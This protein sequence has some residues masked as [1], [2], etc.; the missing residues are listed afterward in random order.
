VGESG[1]GTA[2]SDESTGGESSEGGAVA[3]TGTVPEQDGVELFA[4]LCA[5]C[6]GAEGEGTA[7]AYELRH[8]DREHATWVVRNGRPGVEFETSTMIAFGPA[9]VS[10][11]QLEEIWDWLDAF[12]QRTTGAALY[13]DY[14]R[15][16]HGEDL[17]GGAVGKDIRDKEAGDIHEKV[18]KGEGLGNVGARAFYMPA[19]GADRLSDAEIDA[20]AAFI[21][22]D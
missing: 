3:E 22:G 6:H 2:G 4:G 5:P 8:P 1:S 7:L 14:C 21:A 17:A 12:P 13:A 20:V 16:C 9:V 11:A 18:R 15:N 19:R 10:D